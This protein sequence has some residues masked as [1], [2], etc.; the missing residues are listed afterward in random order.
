MTTENQLERASRF[1]VRAI[2]EGDATGAV[3]APE[4]YTLDPS[5]S[6]VVFSYNHL[7]FRKVEFSSWF[8]G[9]EQWLTV[10]ERL[11]PR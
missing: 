1:Y 2:G 4:K 7:G 5:H 9:N 3:A 10:Q 6:Q 8:E 11:M